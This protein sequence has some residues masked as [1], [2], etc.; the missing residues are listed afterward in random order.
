MTKGWRTVGAGRELDPRALLRELARESEALK[1]AGGPGEDGERFEE[2]LDLEERLLGVFGLPR[3]L[4]YLQAVWDWVASDRSEGS[5]EEL[6]GR[7][8]RAHGEHLAWLAAGREVRLAEGLADGTHPL[9]VLARLGIATHSYTYFLCRCA[10]GEEPGRLL[11]LLDSATEH[12]SDL[13]ALSRDGEAA[14]PEVWGRLRRAGLPG[15]EAFVQGEARSRLAAGEAPEDDEDTGESWES[16]VD[17]AEG[18]E[19][20]GEAGSPHDSF[21]AFIRGQVAEAVAKGAT[22]PADER[23][24]ALLTW[25]GERERGSTKAML[26]SCERV[27]RMYEAVDSEHVEPWPRDES[28]HA[29]ERLAAVAAEG[30]RDVVRPSDDDLVAWVRDAQR[31][32]RDERRQVTRR[33]REAMGTFMSVGA[34]GTGFFAA[35]ERH[36]RVALIQAVLWG[37]FLKVRRPRWRPRRGALVRRRTWA[38]RLRCMRGSRAALRFVLLSS[39]R[40]A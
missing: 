33:F 12:L 25:L 38:A 23:L 24:G 21:E 5:E 34:G 7:L 40:L 29:F 18:D 22:G 39:M 4:P 28:F 19:G 9:D 26:R 8:D 2:V 35:R 20:E 32:A 14:S 13:A 27:L 37:A 31:R 30:G 11:R 15:L 1:A 10:R 16:E 36:R 17:E 6:L 3:S